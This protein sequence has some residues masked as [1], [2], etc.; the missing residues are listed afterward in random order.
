MKVVDIGNRTVGAGQ[1]C[2]IAAEIGINHNGDLELAHRC[3]DAAAE[4]GADAVK[5]QNYRTEDF[6]SDGSLTYEYQSQG[7]TITESQFEMFK[8]CELASE[9][10]IQLRVHCEQRGVIFFSTPTSIKGVEALVELGTPLLKNG[11]DYLVNLPLVRAMA[12]TGLATVLST[13]MA[14]HSEIHDAVTAFREAGGENLIL[15]HCTSSYPTP[16]EDVHLRKI[17]ALEAAFDCPIGFSDHSQGSVAAMGAVALGAC[18][19]E[20]HFTVDKNLPGPDQRFSSDP[21]EFRSLVEAIRTM[22][23]CLGEAK[24]GP[25]ASEERGRRDFRLSCVAACNLQAGHRLSVEDIAF[26]R[27]GSGFLPK[28]ADRLLDI[29]L[30]RDVP[31]GHVFAMEDFA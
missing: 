31:A 4:A 22:E 16:S 13:G 19:V 21:E 1:A 3:I 8:R 10:L 15:A 14:S 18:F 11:S 17:P 27:P 20:K 7:R 26:R 2:F 6:L 28:E 9:S 24:L 30:S 12:K 5:F 29:V 25:A 23:K